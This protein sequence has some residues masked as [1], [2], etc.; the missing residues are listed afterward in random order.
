MQGDIETEERLVSP[1]AGLYTKPN[2][3]S[4]ILREQAVQDSHEYGR[5]AYFQT[6][7]CECEDEGE[8][9]KKLHT[10]KTEGKCWDSF[11][12]GKTFLFI[13]ST[14]HLILIDPV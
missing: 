11:L 9:G 12:G 13:L 5:M 3:R 4:Q 1:T 10:A 14:R 2:W 7:E 6:S 8:G